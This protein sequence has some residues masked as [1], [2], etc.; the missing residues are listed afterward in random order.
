MSD[1]V[2]PSAAGTVTV[3]VSEVNDPPVVDARNASIDEDATIGS[4]ISTVTVTDPDDSIFSFTLSGD[5]TGRFSIDQGG[6]IR[7]AA[8]LDHENTLTH[9]V[10]VKVSDFEAETT[11][12]LQIQVLDVDEVPMAID[13]AATTNEDTSADVDLLANDEDPEGQTLSV[14]IDSASVQ[15]GSLALVDGVATYTPAPD[16]EGNDTFTYRL[17]DPAGNISSSATVTMTVVPVNDSP[18]TADDFGV[19]FAT[20]EDVAFTTVDVRSNDADV[21]DPVLSS[22]VEVTVDATRGALTN[23]GDG[24]FDYAPDPDVFGADT[25]QYRLVD[26]SGAP[27][28]VATVTID[29][30]A[31]NDPPVANPDTLTVITNSAADTVDLRVN[32]A[33]VDG[34]SLTV[35]AVSDGA[36]GTVVSNG[37]G[38]VTYTHDGSATTSDSFSYTVTDPSGASD[39]ALVAVTVVAFPDN[40]GVGAG[41]NCPFAYNPNQLDTDGDGVGDGCDSTP[42]S[43][44]SGT[45]DGGLPLPQDD[46]QAVAVADFDGDGDTDVVFANFGEANK[47]FNNGLGGLLFPDPQDLDTGD[48]LGVAVGDL[49][50]DGSIDIVFANDGANSVWLNDGSGDFSS[51]GQTIGNDESWAVAVGD[52]DGDSDLDLVFG[53]VG[54]ANRLWL[55]NGA[56]TFAPSQAMG[57]R[58][59]KGVVF[60]DLDGDGDLDLSVSNDGTFD[61]IWLNNGAGVF[62]DSGQK[63]G[64]GRS[65]ESVV[66]DLDGDGF[67]D[68]AIAGDNQG[69]TIWLNDGFGQF[70]RTPQNIGIGHSRAIAAGDIDGDGDLDLVFGDHNGANTVWL[71]NGAASFT[72]AGQTIGADATEGIVLV[73][74]DG[75][76]DLGIVVA[77][78]SD[79]NRYYGNS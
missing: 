37:D 40:D 11:E 9:N 2:N 68:I 79:A 76:G 18:V 67:P 47:V 55:N 53:N 3:S 72:D 78:D 22:S 35:S 70:T 61:T 64:I 5:P 49:D 7:V 51:T 66:A 8:P 60:E 17:K 59:S 24:T 19:G 32:D 34:D 33:D 12:S 48:S 13:D 30:G 27:S 29:V 38:T 58:D 74:L 6:V 26:S 44:S 54:E 42:T 4:I 20:S 14:D 77:N 73:D 43:T 21:D 69:D 23:N 65:H 16:Y 75:D 63:L 57:S 56:G 31:L 41:D 46:S 36:S 39:T 1:G 50:G 10:V 45:Y 52:V 28:A 25:F 71:N 62:V 15:G